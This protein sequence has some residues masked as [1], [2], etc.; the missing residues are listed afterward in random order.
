MYVP[1]SIYLDYTA[2]K[3]KVW[4]LMAALFFSP[5]ILR[6][7]RSGSGQGNMLVLSAG[8]FLSLKIRDSYVILGNNYGLG[9]TRKTELRGACETLGIT[10]KDRCVV[11]DH[12]YFTPLSDQV[13]SITL[14]DVPVICEIV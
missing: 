3:F 8:I 1:K 14:R 5:S 7:L 10:R 11:L 13:H 2:L 4:E 6:T 12:K 9:E